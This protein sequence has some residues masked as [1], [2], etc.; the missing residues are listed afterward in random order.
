MP[1]PSL[2]A[3][4]ALCLLATAVAAAAQPGS[5]SSPIPLKMKR[6]TDV[7]VVRGV[8]RQNVDC[9]AYVFEAV[10]G[11]R[12]HWTRTGAVARM[13]MVQPDG[14]IIDPGLPNPADLPLTGT[15]RLLVGPDL[16]ADGAF[17]PFT[18]KLRIPPPGR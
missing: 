3:V 8:L 1:K 7:I 18:L 11:Q 13:G 15:Y 17:G 12:L 6:G 14:Q 16:M 4:A 9:C 5:A 10:A 2:A